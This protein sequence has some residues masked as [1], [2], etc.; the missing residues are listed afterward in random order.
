[1]YYALG[2]LY[3]SLVEGRFDAAYDITFRSYDC[4]DGCL[5]VL[6]RVADCVLG[7]PVV[8]EQGGRS[9]DLGRSLPVTRVLSRAR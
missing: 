2:Y 1:M 3:E 5:H 9:W 4:E 7:C 8:T 6:L